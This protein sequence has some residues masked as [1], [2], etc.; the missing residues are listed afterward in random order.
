[1][2]DGLQRCPRTKMV[3]PL[4]VWSDEQTGALPAQ[5]AHTLEISDIG[6]RLGG[7]RAELAPGQTITLQRGQH[8]ASFRVIWSK[9]LAAHENHAGIEALEPGV[10]IW[11]LNPPP[12]TE[13]GAKAGAVP[14]TS[15]PNPAL[16]KTRVKAATRATKTPAKTANWDVM[17]AMGQRGLRWNV[18]VGLAAVSLA[19]GL[20]FGHRFLF[21]TEDL[22]ISALTRT[23]VPP[24]AEDLARLTPRPHALPVSL[25]R[26]LTPSGSRLLV[27]EAPMGHV[28]YPVA[29]DENITGQVR[30]QI[31]VAANG[32]VKQVHV[33]SGKQPLAEAAAN[34]V[35]LWHYGALSAD[36]QAA[37]HQDSR[38]AGESTERE[39]SVVVSFL[40]DAVS[41]Q[42]PSRKL[43]TSAALSKGH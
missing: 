26:P 6:C 36:P 38:D 43:I 19:L 24:S 23:P 35:R 37:R 18:G 29:P 22:A 21:H 16:G 8:K 5:W 15:N 30:L 2:S 4:R 12:A 27:A 34:A 17:R 33:L 28:V 32:L 39:T 42:F 31:V 14:A 1:M 9:H 7:L 41:L 10:N 13:T 11:A 40:A 3:L 25:S 20:F